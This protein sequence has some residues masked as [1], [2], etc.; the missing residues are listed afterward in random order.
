MVTQTVKQQFNSLLQLSLAINCFFKL[1]N[2]IL[3]IFTFLRNVPSLMFYPHVVR[4]QCPIYI[5]YLRIKKDDWAS[6]CINNKLRI[7]KISILV[8]L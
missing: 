7:V 6:I 5:S 3:K 2:K 8:F 4:G 1:P